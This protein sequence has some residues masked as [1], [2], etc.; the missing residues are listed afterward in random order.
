[1]IQVE[2]MTAALGTIQEAIIIK[3]VLE[4]G[5]LVAL[6]NI[7]I[8]IELKLELLVGMKRVMVSMLIAT[9]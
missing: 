4:A 3:V 9:I 1:M 7:V 8:A 2:K 6:T 5:L